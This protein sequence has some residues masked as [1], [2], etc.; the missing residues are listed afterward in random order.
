MPLDINVD[1]HTTNDCRT[2]VIEDK[3]GNF[4]E[5]NL[6]GWGNFNADPS[7]LGLIITIQIY[8][9]VEEDSI[10][11]YEADYIYQGAINSGDEAEIEFP[12]ASSIKDFKFAI[13]VESLLNSF[14][15]SSDD[16]AIPEDLSELPDAI[17]QIGISTFQVGG[18]SPQPL[19]SN[20]FVFKN[21]CL[22]SKLVSKALTSV[23]LQC[24]DCDDRDLDKVLLAKSLLESLENL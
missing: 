19:S 22:T 4:A 10:V 14:S 23:N 7:T 12:L 15:S 20:S 21:T 6:G 8:Y 11:T 16:M 9:E 13:N 1:I 5:D 24:E 18:Y 3:T 2:L 17:Y